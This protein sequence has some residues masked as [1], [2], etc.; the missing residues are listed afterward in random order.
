MERQPSSSTSVSWKITSYS[1]TTRYILTSLRYPCVPGC[2]TIQPNLGY[3]SSPPLW[4]CLDQT[5]QSWSLNNNT[6]KNERSNS[7]SRSWSASWPLDSSNSNYLVM[8]RL[9][10]FRFTLPSDKLPPSLN[11]YIV[12]FSWIPSTNSIWISLIETSKIVEPNLLNNMYE[13]NLGSVWYWRT[14]I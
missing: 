13:W 2:S 1:D 5:S 12:T 3:R 8:T 9:N 10:M 7:A 6:T 14:R 11:D 4:T